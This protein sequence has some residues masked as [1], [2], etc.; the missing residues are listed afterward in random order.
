M[1][2]ADDHVPARNELLWGETALVKMQSR[3]NDWP[4][5]VPEHLVLPRNGRSGWTPHFIGKGNWDKFT[6]PIDDNRI[7]ARARERAAADTDWETLGAYGYLERAILIRGGK[8]TDGCKT[9]RDIRSRY[10]RLDQLLLSLRA[11]EVLQSRSMQTAGECP[12]EIDGIKVH[13]ARDGG[14]IYFGGGA[15]RLGFA[16][17]LELK[18]IPVSIAKIH[19]LALDGGA[20]ARLRA[21]SRE[22]DLLM[23]DCRSD[24]KNEG[25]SEQALSRPV[26][27]GGL[28]HRSGQHSRR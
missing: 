27:Q 12:L 23:R 9:P 3:F 22:I 24:H 17:G 7:V 21:R 18:Y 11:G 1:C 19:Q 28:A 14:I 6:V 13:I 4:D 10:R 2:E 15:H 20:Y 5:V 8:R 25:T 26:L 16:K